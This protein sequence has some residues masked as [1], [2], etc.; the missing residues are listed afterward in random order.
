MAANG[1]TPTPFKNMNKNFYETEM[2]LRKS[3]QS[4]TL[5]MYSTFMKENIKFW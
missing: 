2:S 4:N 3:R 5:W 1:S